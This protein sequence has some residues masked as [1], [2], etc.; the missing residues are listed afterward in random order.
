MFGRRRQ[1]RQEL[2]VAARGEAAVA[3][4]AMDGLQRQVTDR[5]SFAAHVDGG[6]PGQALLDRARLVSVEADAAVLEWLGLEVTDAADGEQEAAGDPSEEF[7]GRYLEV[8]DRLTRSRE[9]FEQLVIDVGP[10]LH[11]IEQALAV[12]PRRVHEARQ[13]MHDGQAAVEA[14][15]M[16]GLAPEGA[17]QALIRL[18]QRAEM[19]DEGPAVHGIAEILTAADEVIAI[20]GEARRRAE[21]FPHQRDDVARRLVSVRNQLDVTEGKGPRLESVLAA[22][23]R[24]YV[25]AS[26]QDL[27]ESPLRFQTALDDATEALDQAE[28]SARRLAYPPVLRLL[29]QARAALSRA[30]EQV[31]LV[32]ARLATLDALQADPRAPLGPVQFLLDDARSLCRA[33]GS[34][35]GAVRLAALVTRLKAAPELIGGEQPDFYGYLVEVDAIQAEIASVVAELRRV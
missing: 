13:A 28:A 25:E 11:T 15:R 14:L 9:A 3:F 18:H 7:S 22:L 12:I 33:N 27:E 23:R 17:E 29:G 20:A 5:L 16:D 31:R 35:E 34:Q 26:W 4:K 32:T 24:G 10:E 1:D 2:L 8:R 19:L 30:D 6:A 21:Q